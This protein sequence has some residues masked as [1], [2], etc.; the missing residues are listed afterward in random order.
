[1]LTFIC[2]GNA[3][4]SQIAAELCRLAG[5]PARS[6]GITPCKEIHWKTR[7][8]LWPYGVN[9]VDIPKHY[10]IYSLPDENIESVFSLSKESHVY[11]YSTYKVSYSFRNLKDPMPEGSIEDFNLALG[12][13]ALFIKNIGYGSAY[14]ER[15]ISDVFVNKIRKAV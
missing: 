10:S 3:F 2:N 4:R 6:C 14:T 15:I 7:S 13:I 5:V 1:M 11:F 9:I 8:V 12:Q